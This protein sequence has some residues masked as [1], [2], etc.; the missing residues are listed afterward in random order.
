MKTQVS[1]NEVLRGIGFVKTRKALP[2]VHL[3]IK[4]MCKV[5]S[6]LDIYPIG[7][8]IDDG[9]SKDIDRQSVNRLYQHLEEDELSVVIFQNVHDITDDEKDFHKFMSNMREKSITVVDMKTQKVFLP[10]E[11]VEGCDHNE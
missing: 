7:I 4:K 11:A 3:F 1:K 2:N 6:S 8:I 5:A 10:N 9:W